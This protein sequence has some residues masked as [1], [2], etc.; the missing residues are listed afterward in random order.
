[1]PSTCCHLTHS[2][3]SLLSSVVV[4][5]LAIVVS[6]LADNLA[7][8]IELNFDLTTVLTADLDFVGGII[9]TNFGLRD[10]APGVFSQG[11]SNALI[12]G[13]AADRPVVVIRSRRP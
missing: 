12:A 8:L 13:L 6:F 11:G 5:F 7:V 1:M 9:V 4:S 2:G 10:P 3:T